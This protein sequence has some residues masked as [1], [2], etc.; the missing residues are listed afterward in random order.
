M[1]DHTINTWS[2][3]DCE[4]IRR[5]VRESESIGGREAGR[6]PPTF[7]PGVGRFFFTTS[8]ITACTGTSPP[9][10]PGT[11]SATMLKYNSSGQLVSTGITVTLDHG[12]STSIASGRLVQAKR[13]GSKWVID[14]DYC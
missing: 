14:V 3:A 7:M 13:I 4:R 5:T 8:T 11:G 2:D 12:G 1:P 6:S 9:F 10:T